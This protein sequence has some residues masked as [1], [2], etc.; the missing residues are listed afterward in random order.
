MDIEGR[1]DGSN[2]YCYVAAP[3]LVRLRR[4]KLC[5]IGR[6]VCYCLVVMNSIAVATL[7]TTLN[8]Y[9]YIMV[10]MLLSGFYTGLRAGLVRSSLRIGTW[11]LMTAVALLFYPTL[12]MWL[13]DIGGVEK[14]SAN[15]QAFILVGL[16]VYIPCYFASRE[17]M[18]RMSQ[19]SLPAWL[20][21]AGGVLLGAVW[22]VVVIIWLCLVLAVVHSP[23][24]HEQVACNSYVGAR[25]VQPFPSIAA[26]DE[27][28]TSDKPWF[29]EPLKRREEPT[30]DD[31]KSRR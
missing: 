8:W 6:G 27:K 23:F 1:A 5:R 7:P 16:V 24:W 9:D 15:M 21:N 10:L 3:G 18:F 26:M 20:D 22:M 14:D 12:G 25:V 28:K 31:Y 13:N 4:N 19:R 29:M 30:A 17:I 11:I 2:H